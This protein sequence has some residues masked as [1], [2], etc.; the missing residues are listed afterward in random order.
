M[1]PG[2]SYEKAPDQE[3]FFKR[4]RAKKYFTQVLSDRKDSWKFNQSPLFLEFLM[5]KIDY[6]CTPWGNPTRNVFGWQKP[7]YLLNEG[8]TNTFKEM[9]ETTDWDKYG[10]GKNEKCADCMVH[11]GYE[12]TAV[13]DTFSSVKKLM[14]AA[15]A[16]A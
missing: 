16:Q 2:Y 7:C 6:Q 15:K 12:P 3:H 9:M 10:T 1:S 5:G 8:Y 13:I 11:C 4:D 14:Q